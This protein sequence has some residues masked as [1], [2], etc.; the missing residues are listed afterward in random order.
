MAQADELLLELLYFE[1]DADSED[2]EE[3]EDEEAEVNEEAEQRRII[4]T[5]EIAQSGQGEEDQCG[6]SAEEEGTDEGIV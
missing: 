2:D 6:C 1:P 4:A 5:I 3:E